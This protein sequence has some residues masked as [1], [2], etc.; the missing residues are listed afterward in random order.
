SLEQGGFLKQRFAV[1]MPLFLGLLLREPTHAVLRR[2]LLVFL[3]LVYAMLTANVWQ[4]FAEQNRELSEYTAG[5]ESL[6][7]DRTIFVMQRR[8]TQMTT[9]NPLLHAANHYC[10]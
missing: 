10:L 8:S 1:L 5:Q 6:G 3:L 2:G 7:T 4:Y 9:S